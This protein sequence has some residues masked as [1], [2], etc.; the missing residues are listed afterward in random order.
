MTNKGDSMADSDSNPFEHAI[1]RDDF[2][3]VE[4]LLAAE[5][6]KPKLDGKSAAA[7]KKQQSLVEMLAGSDDT[8]AL[9]RRFNMDPDMSEK[10]M[11][12]VLNFLDKYGVGESIS[13]SN[14]GQTAASILEFLTDITPVVRNAMDF[15]G[16]RQRELSQ[17]D[18]DFLEQIKSAQSGSGDMGLFIGETVGEEV[19]PE[20]VVQKPT[21]TQKKQQPGQIPADRDIFTQG[22]DWGEVLNPTAVTVEEEFTE[23]VND[24]FLVAGLERLAAEAG[25]D[26]GN[27]MLSDR[28]AKTNNHG[29]STKEIDYSKGNLN[30][31]LGLEKI[32]EAMKME[33]KRVSHQ[34]KVTFKESENMPVPNN[35]ID[36]NPQDSPNYTI[37]SFAGQLE[38]VEDMISRTEIP[39]EEEPWVAE[40]FNPDDYDIGYAELPEEEF[41]EVTDD[42]TE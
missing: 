23:T 42:D 24:T 8:A 13:G 40:D 25:L 3:E 7:K 22:V 35:L 28:Q 9:A 19:A 41:E 5:R 33:R 1:Q 32:N 10:V 14:S 18:R 30:L 31:D 2:D 11:V 36:G 21:A 6:I 4:R 27:V 17:E 39:E 20:P 38:S 34:S 29:R 26:M 15:F 12:P 37:P 16:G